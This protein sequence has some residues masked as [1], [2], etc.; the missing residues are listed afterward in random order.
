MTFPYLRLPLGTTKPSVSDCLPIVQRIERRLLGCSQF[1][2]QA[3]KLEIINTVL[4]SMTTF[5]MGTL[6]LHSEV[7][8]QAD[9]YTI[10]CLWRG[11]DINA[12]K[13]PLVAWKLVTRPKSEGGPGV[14]NS[15]VHNEALLIK[16][17][18]KF[19]YKVDLP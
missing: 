15:R 18:H 19:Y 3:G 9:K 11:L 8:N 1:L 13:P 17:L 7:I 10:H 5:H 4:S 16:Q 2:T 6:L 14:L 12:K